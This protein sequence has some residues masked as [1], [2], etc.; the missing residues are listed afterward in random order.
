MV[1]AKGL[2]NKVQAEGFAN[3]AKTILA[4]NHQEID[5]ILEA[6]EKAVAF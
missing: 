4:K 2:K 1:N 6:V 5:T 3:E